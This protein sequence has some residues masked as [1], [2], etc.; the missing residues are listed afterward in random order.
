M[1]LLH[2][3]C[4][5]GHDNIVR[6]VNLYILD[7]KPLI[8]SSTKAEIVIVVFVQ[9]R[10][11]RYLLAKMGTPAVT[12]MTKDRANAVHCAACELLSH[13]RSLFSPFSRYFNF[14]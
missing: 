14:M 2:V 13:F 9:R 10:C 7:T 1:S 6:W 5:G 8:S 12:A 11:F 4:I 3:A